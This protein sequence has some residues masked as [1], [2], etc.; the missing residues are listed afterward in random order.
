MATMTILA[1]DLGGSTGY[2]YFEN[3]AVA[4]GVWKL[5]PKTQAQRR[6]E[7]WGVRFNK[8]TAKLDSLPRPDHIV[9]EAVHRHLGTDAA[10]QYGGFLAHLL[11]WAERNDIGYDGVGVGQIK[12]H[13]TGKGNAS[14]EMMVESVRKTMRRE[15]STDDE[16]DALWLLDKA[17]R[18]IGYAMPW[19]CET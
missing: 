15:P 3:G 7:G 1:I 16:A 4:S 6:K 18:D 17:C 5:S 19:D 8:F 13:G 9:Y 12:K 10:H 14:K 2:A 11:A